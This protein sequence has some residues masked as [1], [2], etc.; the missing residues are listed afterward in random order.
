MEVVREAVQISA[1]RLP[2]PCSVGCIARSDS[3]D[4]IEA[5]DHLRNL[6]RQCAVEF[7]ADAF[8]RKC[9]NLADFDR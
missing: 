9:A 6:L 8:N 7:F 1:A 2:R 4:L 5:F 3:D